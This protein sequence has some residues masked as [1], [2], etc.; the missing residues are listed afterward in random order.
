MYIVSVK[1]PY[2][3][4]LV[5]SVNKLLNLV[6]YTF[7]ILYSWHYWVNTCLQL[8]LSSI[9]SPSICDSSG[10]LCPRPTSPGTINSDEIVGQNLTSLSVVGKDKSA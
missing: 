5:T 2:N 3:S 10:E 1:I 9:S 7:V 8:D 4:K 6:T